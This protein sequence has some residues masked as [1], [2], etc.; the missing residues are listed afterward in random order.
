[1]HFSRFDFEWKSLNYYQLLGVERTATADE[2]KRGYRTNARKYHPDVSRDPDATELFKKINEAYEVLGDPLRRGEYDGGLAGTDARVERD[3]EGPEH[4]I[5]VEPRHPNIPLIW[6]AMTLQTRVNVLDKGGGMPYYEIALIAHQ[7]WNHLDA[8]V[9]MLFANSG[10]NWD[11]L[12]TEFGFPKKKVS[13]IPIADMVRFLM[14]NE[15]WPRFADFAEDVIDDILRGDLNIIE[16]STIAGTVKSNMHRIPVDDEN[17]W[18]AAETLL[19]IATE[20]E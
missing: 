16:R 7:R 1:M 11:K 8:R 19:Y 13:E 17:T 9:Q 3:E 14:K 20:Y 12:S 2:I 4:G 6:E 10:Q 18:D 5:D 15:D